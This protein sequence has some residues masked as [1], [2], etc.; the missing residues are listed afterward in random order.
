VGEELIVVPE[1]GSVSSSGMPALADN[2]VRVVLDGDGTVPGHL[3]RVKC[4]KR[5]GE[6]L[7]GKILSGDRAKDKEEPV[8]GE[9]GR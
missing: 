7:S 9:H 4:E 6:M 2:Y 5:V 8:Q 1:P 3:V